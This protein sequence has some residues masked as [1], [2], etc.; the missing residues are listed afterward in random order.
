MQDSRLAALIILAAASLVVTACAPYRPT[1]S[2]AAV[3]N[4]LNSEMVFS[5]STGIT[6]QA[7]IQNANEPGS[8][9]LTKKI[10]AQPVKRRPHL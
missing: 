3:C 7:N 5:G 6:R 9:A 2:K 10:T 8:P 1:S 4:Q